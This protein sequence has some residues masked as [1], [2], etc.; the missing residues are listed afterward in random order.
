L[1]LTEQYGIEDVKAGTYYGL[2]GTLLVAYG[3]AL[4]GAIDFLGIRRSLVLCFLMNLGSRVVMSTT[5]SSRLLIIMLLGPN[6]LASCLGVPVLTIA[7]KRFTTESNRGFA[8]SLFY[9]LMNVAALSQVR[10]RK[11]GTLV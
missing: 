3:F 8:F 11:R 1:Y 6:A 4:G 2:W 5:K 10:K 7:V 9:T